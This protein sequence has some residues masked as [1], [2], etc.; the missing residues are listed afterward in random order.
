[1]NPFESRIRGKVENVSDQDVVDMLIGEFPSELHQRLEE[2]IDDMDEQTAEDFLIR[3]LTARKESLVEWSV[4]ELSHVVEISHDVPLAV[5]ASIEEASQDEHE[6]LL[7][8]GQNGKVYKSVRK[9]YACYKVLFL[10]RARELQS[11]ILR[12]AMLQYQAH[13]ALRDVPDAARVPEVLGFVEHPDVLAI[14]MGRVEG[15]SVLDILEGKAFLPEQFDL[16]VCF[17]K[18]ETAVRHLNEH[19]IYHRDLSNNSGN[20]LIDT[21]GDPWIIDFGVAAH[22]FNPSEDGQRYQ[23]RPGG[24]SFFANDLQGVKTLKEKVQNY[25][26]KNGIK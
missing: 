5:L 22:G 21:N 26:S 1:M 13:Q 3:K 11:S 6:N 15:S 10:Q 2:E 20:I 12:E 9:E 16:D 14:M 24:A 23:L 19:G 17:D 8:A 7:G 4:E 18:L 25:V